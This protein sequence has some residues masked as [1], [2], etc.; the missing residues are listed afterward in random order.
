MSGILL[1]A[2]W[3]DSIVLDTQQTLMQCKNYITFYAKSKTLFCGL[4]WCHLY[5]FCGIY[6]I[7]VH[8]GNYWQKLRRQKLSVGMEWG[9]RCMKLDGVTQLT[10]QLALIVDLSKVSTVRP[11][12]DRGVQYVG[13]QPNPE[14]QPVIDKFVQFCNPLKF[15]SPWLL[16]ARWSDVHQ[17]VTF[18]LGR[19]HVTGQD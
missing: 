19:I 6:Q 11:V 14:R 7:S 17:A 13:F 15:H 10:S 8:S 5:S 9:K 18:L 1:N 2:V 4:R 3:D 12:C 16:C